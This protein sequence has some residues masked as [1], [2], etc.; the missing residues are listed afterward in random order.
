M[1]QLWSGANYTGTPTTVYYNGSPVKLQIA[2][3]PIQSLQVQ[4][5][6]ALQLFTNPNF[7]GTPYIFNGP[8]NI[9]SLSSSNINNIQSLILSQQSVYTTIGPSGTPVTGYQP[10]SNAQNTQTLAQQLQATGQT[11]GIPIS[12]LENTT[13]QLGNLDQPT[14]VNPGSQNRQNNQTLGQIPP[15]APIPT[16][17]TPAKSSNTWLYIIIAI[18]VIIIII[19]VVGVIIYFMLHKSKTTAIQPKIPI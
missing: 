14:T 11:I 8:I 15:T 16:S 12:G 6:Y 5:G 17:A 7:Q 19:I 10:L 4:Q 18:V 13:I 1:A 3:N 2:N 9:Q